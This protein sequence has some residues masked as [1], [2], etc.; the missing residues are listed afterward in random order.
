MEVSHG[1]S[2]F[3]SSQVGSSGKPLWVIDFRYRDKDGKERRY[4]RDAT[5]QSAAAARAEAERLHIQAVTTGTLELK[6][7]ASMFREF[8][9]GP[10]TKLYMAARCRPS[11]RDRY[12][13]LFRQGLLDAFGSKRLDEI[14]ATDFRRYGAELVGRGVQSRPHLSLVRTVLRAAVELGALERLPELPKLPKQSKKLPDA[15][16]TKEVQLMLV[17]AEGWLRIAIALS[18][19]AGLRMGEVRAIEVR[20]VDLANGRL[21]V[22]RAFSSDEVMSPKSGDERVVPLSPDL[23]A[24]LTDAIRRKL[25]TARVLTNANGRTPTRQHVLTVIKSLQTR[26]GL[27]ERSFHSLRHYFCSVLIRHGASV[28]AVR[29]LAGHSKLDVTQRYV[30]AN[31]ADLTAAIAMLPG[32]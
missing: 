4:R 21:F 25:P 23:R 9:E 16:T 1:C 19:L 31:A 13:A 29:V 2:T 8:A 20:D 18:A 7:G 10:F 30:H 3:S 27:K 5:V 32:N 28:E 17:H 26:H 12:L 24:V 14:G 15:P 22:R 6:S 11:T